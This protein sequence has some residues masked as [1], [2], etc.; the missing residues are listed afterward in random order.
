MSGLLERL[1]TQAR[2]AAERGA[3]IRPASSVQPRQPIALPAAGA[4][5]LVG[6]DT[7]PA[8]GHGERPQRTFSGVP[9]PQT[10]LAPWT[11]EPRLTAPVASTDDEPPGNAVEVELRREPM[12]DVATRSSAPPATDERSRPPLP[13]T[14]L[15]PMTPP[16]SPNLSWGAGFGASLLR[17]QDRESGMDAPTEVHVHIGR[18]E[19]RTAHEPPAPKKSRKPARETRPLADYLSRGR[20]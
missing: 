8:A 10:P 6:L 2:G 11:S 9:S 4:R 1:A 20:S 18:I 17:R 13:A 15:G 19:V 14:L 7:A 3:R 16:A 5:S 12:D